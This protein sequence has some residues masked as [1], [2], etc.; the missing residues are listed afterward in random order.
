MAFNEMTT[1]T[2]FTWSSGTPTSTSFE[3]LNSLPQFVNSLHDNDICKQCGNVLQEAHQFS[4]G[5]LV[6]QKCI[7]V[8]FGDVESKECDLGSHDDDEEDT[9]L[10]KNKVNYILHIIYI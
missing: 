4:C 6:C 8:F 7:D 3:S 5:H 9:L 1:D 10:T 2:D